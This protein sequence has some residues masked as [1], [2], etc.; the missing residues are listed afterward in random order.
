MRWLHG[1][2]SPME[3]GECGSGDTQYGEVCVFTFNMLEKLSVTLLI[4][5]LFEPKK[6]GKYLFLLNYENY[7]KM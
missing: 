3:F 2:D 6:K 7:G 4:R 1:D 5:L